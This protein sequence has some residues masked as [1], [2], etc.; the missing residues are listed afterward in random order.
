MFLSGIYCTLHTGEN[1]DHALRT[2]YMLHVALHTLVDREFCSMV[3]NRIFSPILVF[4]DSILLILEHI[5]FG[6]FF[7]MVVVVEFG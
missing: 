1:F 2:N 3:G 4:S 6:W 7:V 5:H